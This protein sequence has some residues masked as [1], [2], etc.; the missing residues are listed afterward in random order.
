MT[1][2]KHCRVGTRS[3]QLALWQTRHVIAELEK[4]FPE[5]VFEV[6]EMSTKGDRILNQALSAIGDK[7]LFTRD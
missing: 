6:V 2:K 4:R 5:T 1:I 7:G 3:S